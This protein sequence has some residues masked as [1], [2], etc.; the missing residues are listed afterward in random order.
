MIHFSHFIQKWHEMITVY[1]HIGNMIMYNVHF[2]N[3]YVSVLR[4]K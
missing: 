1:T 2:T 3:C 4:I